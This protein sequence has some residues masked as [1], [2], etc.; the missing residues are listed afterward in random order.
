MIDEDEIHSDEIFR[1][2]K[3]LYV[4]YI[5]KCNMHLFAFIYKTMEGFSF[6]R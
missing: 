1:L 6:Y 5:T 4:P 2:S 3:N